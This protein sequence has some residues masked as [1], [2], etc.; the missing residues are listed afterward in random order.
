MTE[1]EAYAALG[2][3]PNGNKPNPFILPATGDTYGHQAFRCPKCGG[4]MVCIA[5]SGYDGGAI[6]CCGAKM[7]EL[8]P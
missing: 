4:G 1:L 5:G 3:D 6:C 8:A 7:M 2:W